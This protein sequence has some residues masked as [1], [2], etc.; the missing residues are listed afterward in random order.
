MTRM[1]EDWGPDFESVP[2]AVM[3]FLDWYLTPA[4]LREDDERTLKGWCTK[5]GHSTNWASN[6]QREP[7]FDRLFS[8]RF[9]AIGFGQA[10]F[11]AVWQNY[12]RA[13]ATSPDFRAAR[14]FLVDMKQ[15]L[16]DAPLAE[17][18]GAPSNEELV[19]RHRDLVLAELPSAPKEDS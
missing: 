3:Q 14:N 4:E 1:Y 7:E 6:L 18:D 8:S 11:Y 17:A 13:A 15:I 12:Y 5:N 10:H 19:A 16:T 9:E 2:P